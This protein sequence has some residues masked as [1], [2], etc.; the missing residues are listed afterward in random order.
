MADSRQQ[1]ADCSP[2][3][4]CHLP[5]EGP[6]GADLSYTFPV[7]DRNAIYAAT[8]IDA[9]HRSGVAHACITPGSRS[10]PLALAL[11]GSAITDWSHHDE[12]SSAFFALGIARTT[13]RPVVI[14]TTSG[15]AAAELHPALIEARHA[16]VPLIAITADRPFELR[17]VG[18]AQTI[19]QQGLFGRSVK[20]AH[21]TAV[22]DPAVTGP[23]HVAALA[24]RL[25]AEA[26]TPPAG[27]VHLNL[28]F[29]E[30][31]MPPGPVHPERVAVPR[32]VAGRLEL[33]A[34]AIDALAEQMA[35]RRG[36]VMAGPQDDPEVPAAVVAFAAACGWPIL[37][38]PLSGVR[39]GT[40]DLSQVLTASDAL[41]WAGFIDSAAP[42]VVVRF[43]AIPTSKPAGQ[44]L[45]R[46]RDATQILIDPTG[47]RDPTASAGVV[48]RADPAAT[49]AAL[50]QAVASPTDPTWIERW[51]SA[52]SAAC[53]A[54]HDL[55]DVAP[56]PNEPA[57]ARTVVESVPDRGMLWVAS[58]MPIRDL[59][60]VMRPVARPLTVRAN[61][62]ANG[63][64]GFLSTVLGAA[65]ATVAP[66]IGLAGDLSVLHDL[67]AL[68]TAARLGIPATLVAVNNDGGGIF[69]LLPQAGHPHFE[70]YWGTPHGLD[71]AAVAT[72]LGVKSE[73]VIDEERLAEL[74]SATAHRPR[75]VE[76]RTDR[77][78]NADLHR[79]I[80]RVVADAV[81]SG[82]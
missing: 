79:R 10:T 63:I 69:H 8:L 13:R 64:D 78:E 80:R 3:A 67:G 76:V 18:A 9:L 34:A 4:I 46:H 72:A 22:P 77:T 35:G 16:G 50:A 7:P 70:R 43:G 27:P 45:E 49:L 41:G 24:A 38:D 62:G 15:T 37:A 39:A 57:I 56:F 29:R 58:S 74:V 26:T 47:W 42:E 19:D 52:D 30:P 53:A 61:R 68:A 31:L 12:R 40:H 23:A 60:T 21:D 6:E 11:A 1:T 48:V 82:S 14:V 36:L 54:L 81:A 51:R 71:L 65:S 44:W 25:V 20:W 32:V 5:S 75:F 59:D 55:I 73:V 2:S 33:T 28:R 66:T 17:D